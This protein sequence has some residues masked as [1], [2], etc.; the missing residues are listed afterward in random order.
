MMANQAWQIASP[1]KLVLNDAGDKPQPGSNEAL[2]RIHAV[3]LNYRDRLVTD[4]S[5][6]YPTT[7]KPY[8]I[9][10]ADGAGVVEQ[11][12]PGSRWHAGDRV[13]IHHN[14][15]M[16]GTK[17]H[18]VDMGEIFAGT[19]GAGEADGTLRRWMV[20]SDEKLVKMP[21]QLSFEEASTMPTAGLTA[22]RALFYGVVKAKPGITVLTQ[23]TG[24]VSSFA[25]LVCQLD[26]VV[27][28][29]P[30]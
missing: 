18:D 23:G 14:G 4:H 8:L 6:V 17:E 13:V 27:I 26:V 19:L 1:G 25:I 2:V 21:S 5:P 24:G 7:A 28:L 20:R 12:G 16:T 22:Y 11:A 3:S 9:P 15:W 10:C 29:A 30:Y